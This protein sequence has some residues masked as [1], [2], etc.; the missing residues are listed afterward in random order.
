V[1]RYLTSDLILTAVGEQLIRPLQPR[2][3]LKAAA[4]RNEVK[5]ATLCESTSRLG[6]VLSLTPSSRWHLPAKSL[7]FL[8][9]NCDTRMGLR[10]GFA[11]SAARSRMGELAER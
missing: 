3:W 7:V 8:C 5:N 6:A 10:T 1:Q 4:S 2:R 11:T 9:R